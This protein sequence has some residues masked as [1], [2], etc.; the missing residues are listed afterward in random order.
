[1]NLTELTSETLKLFLPIEKLKVSEWAD[2]FRILSSVNSAEPGQWD[3]SRAEYQRELMD[4][5]SDDGV[6]TVVIKASAQC[7]KSEILNNGIGYIMSHDPGPVMMV[8]PTVDLA[9][10]YSKE[11]LAPM[12][13]SCEVLK[14][15]VADSK[16]RDSDNTILTKR[17]VGGFLALVGAN[18]PSGLRSRPIRYLFLDEVDAFPRSAG[19]EG[20]PIK[21]AIKRTQTFYN[22]K[23]V[24]CSTPTIKNA[25]TID[26]E[27]K[28]GT[29]EEWC[30]ACPTCKS[31][32]FIDFKD[33]HFDYESEEV[34]E[35]VQYRVKD[36]YFKCPHC[37]AEHGEHVMKAG[38]CKWIARNKAALERKVRSFRI[39]AFLSP[40]QS[41]K[42]IAETFLVAKENREELQV[43]YN[44]VLGEVWELKD[45][46]GRPEQMLSRRE[47]YAA[48]VPAGALV[49]TCGIDTQDNRLE[50]E[51]KGWGKDEESWG[52]QR[53]VIYGAPDTD[54]PW[55]E[56]DEILDREWKHESGSKIR[57]SVSFI[58]SGGHYT[59]E[60]YKQCNKRL[61]KH[62]FAIKG[63]SGQGFPY[64]E[65]SKKGQL[66]FLIGV[67]SG[68]ARLMHNLNVEEA[69]P[70]YCH[71]PIEPSRG[72]NL[73]YFKSL[74]SERMTINTRKG[75]NHIVW[76][77]VEGVQRNE[78]WDCNNYNLAAIT[79]FPFDLDK[80][81]NRLYGEENPVAA[82][83]P[84][85]RNRISGGVVI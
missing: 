45:R 54:Q 50:Y 19:A 38:R 49:L 48:E 85:N 2:Q 80:I 6:E 67:D 57:I 59:Q 79:A 70:K 60:V 43:F 77:L 72:Y 62:L 26:R 68:K 11:R 25:S 39:N 29:Q 42:A 76:E 53:G 35:Q 27:Y 65:R 1:M 82:K 34:G 56:L 28:R 40:W 30:V 41:W 75:R 18:A 36:I 78:M 31:Y 13:E 46:S 51:V 55:K 74:L 10:A 8:Q 4:A 83:K 12:I 44:T 21:L 52:I 61:G 32:H 69:G 47:A 23:I 5:I 7:G 63:R 37:G 20:D 3:T 22:R 9:K 15:V 81:R 58:D 17:F 24:M 33:I 64:I 71:F 73:E 14:N 84:K 16:T 66:L